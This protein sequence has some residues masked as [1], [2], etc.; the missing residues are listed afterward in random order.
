MTGD[1][2]SLLKEIKRYNLCTFYLLPLTGLTRFSFG[3]GLFVNSY[4]DPK[5]LWIIVQIADLELIPYKSKL[6]AHAVKTWQDDRGGFLAYELLDM[7]KDDIHAYATGK[8]SRFSSDLKSISFERSGLPY[9][10]SQEDGSI[11]TDI[12]LMALDGKEVVREYIEDQLQVT[13]DP[14]Q[15]V[16]GPPLPE[17]FMDAEEG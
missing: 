7:W 8:Y 10:E 13:L 4:L 14:D 12:R 2:N 1:F 9:K 6:R 11:H 3:E 15:E 16:L 17:S 5:R